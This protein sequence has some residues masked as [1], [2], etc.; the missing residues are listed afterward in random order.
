MTT[1]HMETD[2]ARSMASQIKQAVEQSREKAGQLNNSINAVDWLGP[3]RDEFVMEVE[4][5][6]RQLEAQAEV[7]EALAGRVE[8]EVSEWEQVAASLG[9]FGGAGAPVSGGGAWVLPIFP[10][11]PVIPIFTIVSIAPWLDN[12]PP[13]LHDLYRKFF[14]APAP[15][16]AEPAAPVTKSKLGELIDQPIEPPPAAP[17]EPEVIMP[18]SRPGYDTYYDI[19]PKSQ[20][21]AYGGAACLPTSISMLT[22]YYHNQDSVNQTASRDELIKMLDEGD[23]TYGHGVGLN[24][25]NDDLKE[26]GYDEI[27]NFQSDLN[28]LD[29]ELKNGPVVVNVKVDLTSSPTR[30]IVEGNTYNHSILVKGISG[31]SVLINDPW[32]GQ[33]IEM[34]R[35]QFDR[36]WSNGERWIQTIYP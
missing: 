21:G 17:A 28:G 14:P 32:S 33:E 20:D 18:P 27:R 3:S 16:P 13:W 4:A 19:P 8:R 15:I 1:F 2:V 34:P 11:T 23:G 9:G 36:M 35:D 31:S 7:G 5:I 6:S 10:F 24:K 29:D 25:L 26:L 22:D 30:M 12:L